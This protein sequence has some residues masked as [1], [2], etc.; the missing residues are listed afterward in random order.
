M[1]AALDFRTHDGHLNAIATAAVRAF[2]FHVNTRRPAWSRSLFCRP[3]TT[4]RPLPFL[5]LAHRRRP[6]ASSAN[7]GK[8]MTIVSR[9][10]TGSV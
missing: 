7:D 1:I 4:R 10:K 9:Q 8:G 2:V 5:T 6:G 3:D